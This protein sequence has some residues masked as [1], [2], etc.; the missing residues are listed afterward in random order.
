MRSLKKSK[1]TTTFIVS[2]ANFPY[3][4]TH[5]NLFTVVRGELRVPEEALKHEKFTSQLQLSQK[6]SEAEGSKS[7]GAK[8]VEQKVQDAIAEVHHK[9][10]ETLKS[11][12]KS[13]DLS[14]MPR[15]TPLYGQPSWWGDDETEE[16]NGCK[17]D[18]KPEEK[19]QET[20]VSDV[21]ETISSDW[22]IP[23]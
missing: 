6:S 18:S 12:D 14:A 20:G 1:K 2:A 13:T 11:E 5:T 21:M 9:A 17:Q 8:T 15:G 22:F 23:G 7:T 3:H 4:I 10:V 19:I 16:Q